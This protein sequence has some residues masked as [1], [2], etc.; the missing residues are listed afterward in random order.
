MVLLLIFTN[1]SKK[2]VVEAS[3][4]KVILG[5]VSLALVIN[6]WNLS[7]PFDHFM[8]MSSMYLY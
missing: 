8:K 4:V 2:K 5:C 1:T 6:C 3:Y 7:M